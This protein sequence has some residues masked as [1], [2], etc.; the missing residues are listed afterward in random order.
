MLRALLDGL[1]AAIVA[2]AC[3]A[4]ERPLETPAR[5]AV[6]DEC[7]TSIR[8]IE[9]PFCAICGEP[10]RSWRPTDGRKCGRCSTTKRW[11][12]C[13]RAVG[14]YDGALREILHAFKYRGRRSIG[15]ALSSL[16]KAHGRSVLAGATCV[17]PV[18][19]H[20]R[21]R[22]SRGFNQAEELANGLG[23]PIVHALRRRRHTRSQ[24][25]LPASRRHAN[26]R[27]AFQPRRPIRGA[28]V[29]LVD[30]VSTTG[31]TLEACAKVLLEAGAAEVRALTAARAARRPSGG[32][33]R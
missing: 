27:R 12:S 1:L 16:M 31:A 28:C 8:R 18:P 30:D 21:R 13:A 4:C 26:V 6:C 14:E 20:W 22:W 9:P 32:R 33:P 2:P 24:T 7:W 11:I 25:D 29:V 10:L 23:L 17:V 19:L 3:A 5:S 15:P